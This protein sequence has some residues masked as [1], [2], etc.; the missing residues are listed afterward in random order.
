MSSWEHD[1]VESITSDRS[2][3][4]GLRSSGTGE[5]AAAKSNSCKS[6][7]RYDR[8]DGRGTEGSDYQI[9]VDVADADRGV[10]VLHYFVPHCS[11]DTA[12][13]GEGTTH[14]SLK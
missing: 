3:S 6:F 5:V 8:Q 7:R 4:T 12:P 11:G 13:S 10:L 2:T 1:V 14:D 9:G